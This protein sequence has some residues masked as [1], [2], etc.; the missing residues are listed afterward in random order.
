MANEALNR[1]VVDILVTLQSSINSAINITWST[2]FD[3]AE[4]V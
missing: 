3:D 4:V 1:G 2:N